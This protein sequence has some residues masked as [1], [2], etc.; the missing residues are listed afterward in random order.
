MRPRFEAVSGVWELEIGCWEL[1]CGS[2]RV[3]L[4]FYTDR[5]NAIDDILRSTPLA[6]A[7]AA[8]RGEAEA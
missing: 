4:W 5:V 7:D 3:T 2:H 6:V 1:T 8:L